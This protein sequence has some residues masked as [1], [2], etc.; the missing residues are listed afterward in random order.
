MKRKT[1]IICLM[2]IMASAMLASPRSQRQALAEAQN[3]MQGKGINIAKSMKMSYRM[4]KTSGSN[5]EASFFVF[6]VGD[7]EGFV[8]VSGDAEPKTIYDLQGRRLSTSFA[9]LPKG[10]YIIGN[11]KVV[12]N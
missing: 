4:P 10:I 9:N 11:K 6:N 1:T 5:D 7:D 12:K 2:L 8:I 3:F